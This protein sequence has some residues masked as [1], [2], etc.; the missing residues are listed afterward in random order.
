M[1]PANASPDWSL[2]GGESLIW[3]GRPHTR[4][5]FRL[6][7]AFSLPGLVLWFVLLAFLIYGLS[8]IP[9]PP[10]VFGLVAALATLVLLWFG[11]GKHLLDRAQRR[12]IHYA[13]TNQRA[14]IRGGLL[15][16]VERSYSFVT[17]DDLAV[18]EGHNGCGS[19]RFGSK[20]LN[21][22]IAHGLPW[23]DYLSS[24]SFECLPEVRD[25]YRQARSHFEA[26][27]ATSA[28]QPSN[29]QAWN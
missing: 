3:E 25:V 23:P 14:L 24:P 9:V 11:I 26:A 10:T 29:E 2:R 8:H 20:P 7:D 5:V 17:L 1:P 18:S 19:V 27:T 12:R 4:L 6:A 21:A 15:R 16:P 13:L 22:A 28:Q